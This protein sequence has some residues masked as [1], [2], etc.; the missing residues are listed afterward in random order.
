MIKVWG[1]IL[2]K[3]EELS[4]DIY[5]TCYG[6]GSVNTLKTGNVNVYI[7]NG[8]NIPDYIL[9]NYGL[10]SSSYVSRPRY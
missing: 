10:Q 1:L 7:I 4:A 6:D 9:N 3:F 8:A 2:P 5:Y